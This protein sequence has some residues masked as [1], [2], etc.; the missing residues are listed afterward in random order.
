ME[1]IY[2]NLKGSFASTVTTGRTDKFQNEGDNL[3]GERRSQSGLLKWWWWGEG[4]V[5]GVFDC[6]T[7]SMGGKRGQI[8]HATNHVQQ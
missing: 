7:S 1:E 4:G 8:R 2:S 3:M 5:W 6:E